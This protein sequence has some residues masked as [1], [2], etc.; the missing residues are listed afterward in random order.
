MTAN[1]VRLGTIYETIIYLTFLSG[2]SLISYG[3]AKSRVAAI[4]ET[5]AVHLMEAFINHLNRS[6]VELEEYS[7]LRKKLDSRRLALDAAISKAEKTYKKEKDKKEAQD[8][9]EKAQLRYEKV[10][11]DVQFRM[12]TIKANEAVHLEELTSLLDSETKFVE[13]YLS[14]LKGIRAEWPEGCVIYSGY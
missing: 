7:G 6:L 10:C 14:I 13:E 5:Y 2:K 9:L 4:Q 1:L 8:E 11:E 12:D 3:R